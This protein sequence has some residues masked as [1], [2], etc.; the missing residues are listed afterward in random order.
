MV[1]FEYPASEGLPFDLH[2]LRNRR[3]MLE[4]QKTSLGLVNE[5][6]LGDDPPVIQQ[7]YNMDSRHMWEQEAW[8]EFQA[9][10]AE[11]RRPIVDKICNDSI[12]KVRPISAI[13]LNC[14]IAFIPSI[15]RRSVI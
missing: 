1:T 9:M 13:C 7:G 15:D 4:W 14:L 8:K 6:L 10:S 2:R 5:T 11:E 12:E 3:I